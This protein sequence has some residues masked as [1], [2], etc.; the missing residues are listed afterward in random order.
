MLRT[1]G[2]PMIKLIG[3]SDDDPPI[4]ALTV[5][6][7]APARQLHAWLSDSDE[8][9]R[10]VGVHL[11]AGTDLDDREVRQLSREHEVRIEVIAKGTG[12]TESML[13]T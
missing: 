1:S 8:D 9:V 13:A 6:G 5:S 12:E 10:R 4:F 11:E 7:R 3:K 2:W